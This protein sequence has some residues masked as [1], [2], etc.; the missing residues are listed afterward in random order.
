LEYVKQEIESR[1]GIP[2]YIQG[3]DPDSMNQTKGGM[4]ILQGNSQ[5]RLKMYARNFAESCLKP[6]FRGILYLLAKNQSKPLLLRLRNTFTPIDPRAWSTEYDMTVNVGLGSGAKDQ[7]LVHLQSLS[8]DLAMAGQSPFGGQLLDAKKVFN[9]FEAKAELA[10]FKDATK[11]MNNPDLHPPPPPPGPP[12]PLQIEQAKAQAHMQVEGA[13]LQ[14]NQASEQARMQA[15]MQIERVRM[16]AKAST[17]SLRA[18]LDTQVALIKQQSEQSLQLAIAKIKA[19]A[20][21]ISA[22]ITATKQADA[23]EAQA[24]AAFRRDIQ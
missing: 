7:Q 6:L 14:A 2:R 16:E 10:G 1:T 19:E 3:F 17:D 23:A 5:V 20:Q 4:Q 12:L 9:L 24:E 13:K 21:I 8:Q 18:H 15:D 11:F 22:D